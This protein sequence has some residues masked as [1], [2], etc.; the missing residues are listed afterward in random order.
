M[1]LM[2]PSG[3]AD[4]FS[5]QFRFISLCIQLNNPECTKEEELKAHQAIRRSRRS[6]AR[7][8]KWDVS[9]IPPVMP[10]L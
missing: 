10:D 3:P 6:G 8:I 9:D 5:T 4:V 1:T 2:V 7:L